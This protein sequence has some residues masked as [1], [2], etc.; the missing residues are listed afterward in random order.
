M[1]PADTPRN[2]VKLL[3]NAAVK[4][5]E[6]PDVQQAISRQGLEIRTSSLEELAARIKSETAVWAGIIKDANI[7]SD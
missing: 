5:L 6:N 4:A 3:H 7:K 1:V 2:I